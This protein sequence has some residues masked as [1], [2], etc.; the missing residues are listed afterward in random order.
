MPTP[1]QRY[2]PILI[3]IPHFSA[4]RLQPSQRQRA[5]QRSLTGQRIRIVA[6]HLQRPVERVLMAI[7]IVQIVGGRRSTGSA[8]R[9]VVV[10]A[11]QR[12]NDGG[13]RLRVGRTRLACETVVRIRCE[14]ECEIST[15]I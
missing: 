12:R 4:G 1:G 8:G 13:G 10:V 11:A 5:R 6:V 7:V 14:T 9:C 3:I 15:F 2:S